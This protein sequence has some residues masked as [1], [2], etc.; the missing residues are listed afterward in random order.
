MG[1]PRPQRVGTL[2]A[3]LS[4]KGR[5]SD[6]L[7][8]LGFDS[9]PSNPRRIEPSTPAGQRTAGGSP[10]QFKIHLVHDALH[11]TTEGQAILEGSVYLGSSL[12]QQSS[13]N[14]FTTGQHGPGLVAFTHAPIFGGAWLYQLLDSLSEALCLGFIGLTLQR[15]QTSLYPQRL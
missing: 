8:S 6:Q 11:C 12:S 1:L 10:L 2:Q 14:T 5:L 13:R 15:F 9:S 7:P 3:E 4:P